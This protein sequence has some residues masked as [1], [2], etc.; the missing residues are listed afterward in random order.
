MR[1]ETATGEFVAN[2]EPVI[3]TNG[4]LPDDVVLWG[5]RV[6]VRH[7]VGKRHVQHCQVWRETLPLVVRLAP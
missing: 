3:P 2:V 6:F 4:T 5:E 1:L 7:C